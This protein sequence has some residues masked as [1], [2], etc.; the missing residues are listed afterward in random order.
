MVYV[1]DVIAVS[2]ESKVLDKL[3]SNLQKKEFVLTKDGTLNKYLGV[4]VKYKKNGSFE[5]IQPFLIER[6]LKLMGLDG[7]STVNTRDTHAVKPILHKDHKGLPRKHN[8]N[9]RQAIGMLKYL[10]GITTSRWP[11]ISVHASA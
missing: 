1:D 9:Y 6:F 5:L 3:V 10:Q 8:W 4:N 7:D 11:F 2:R